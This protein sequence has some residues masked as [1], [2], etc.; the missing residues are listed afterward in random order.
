MQ[1]DLEFR[2][3]GPIELWSGG[4]QHDLGAART[5]C[6]LAILL[7]APGKIVPAE[8]LIDRLW[9]TR[10]PPKARESLSAYIARLRGSLRR[11]LGDSVWLAGRP[12][13]YVPDVDPETVDLFRF[14]RLRRQADALTATGDYDHAVSLLREADGLWRGQALAG[15][16]GDWVAR[17]RD[18][19]DEERRAAIVARVQCDLELGRHAGLVGELSHLFAAYPLDETFIAH[20]MTA[21]YRS[22]RPGD[23]LGL[24]RETR[25][26]LVEELG[27]E[28]GP[29][30]SELHQRILRGDPQLAVSAGGHGSG[31]RPAQ[32]PFPRRWSSCGSP[33]GT[34]AAHREVG[35]PPLVSVIEG[36]PGVG[37]TALAVQAARIASS[38]YPDGVVYLNFH[39]HDPGQPPLDAP[40][41]L[42]RLLQLLCVPSALIPDAIGERIALWRAQL[43]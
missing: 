42:H 27:T 8:A 12:G 16:G 23:A 39:T 40:E 18:G 33:E 14:R 7:L 22:G 24:Y 21:L 11:A 35:D 43:S 20:Q 26:R 29:T 3:L 1:G 9:D 13:G 6:V 34:R 36:M 30:L 2:V 41:A 32:I 10:P 28:P 19:L 25:G 31:R 4:Q 17:T 5:R 37:K 38:Q 15:I